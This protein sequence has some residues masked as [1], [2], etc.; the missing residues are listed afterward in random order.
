V[1]SAVGAV[2]AVVVVGVVVGRFWFGSVVEDWWCECGGGGNSRG[3]V[4]ETWTERWDECG[5]AGT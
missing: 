5:G 1:R 3:T 4:G 2:V